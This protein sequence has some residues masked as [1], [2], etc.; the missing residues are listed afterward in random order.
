MNL[1]CRSKIK[2]L[3]EF[4]KITTIFNNNMTVKRVEINLLG[5]SIN[6]SK[7]LTYLVTTLL[8]LE[9]MLIT[10][11]VLCQINKIINLI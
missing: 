9:K 8:T 7:V 10:T 4:S 3:R 5:S 2:L 6:L 1:D 11:I